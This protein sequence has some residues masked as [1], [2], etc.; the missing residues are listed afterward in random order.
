MQLYGT[1]GRVFRCL[2]ML[3]EAGI[4]YER[5]PVDWS[6]G[7]SR[8]PA[9]LVLNPNG[10]VPL[11]VD[12]ELQLFESLAINYHLARTCAPDLW[13]ATAQAMAMAPYLRLKS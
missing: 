9:F 12:G 2:W 11:L 4:D 8:T 6:L 13:V 5:V 1:G 3:E 7:E 10:K